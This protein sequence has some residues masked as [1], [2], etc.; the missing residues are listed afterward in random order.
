MLMCRAGI[1]TI[2]FPEPN[3]ANWDELPEEIK[4]GLTVHFVTYYKEV[5]KIAF[6]SL[7][8]ENS[9]NLK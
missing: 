5:F 4:E 2:I 7:K 1:K 8:S 9:V 3:R 6:P